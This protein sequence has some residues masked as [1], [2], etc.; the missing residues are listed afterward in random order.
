MNFR[1]YG[2]EKAESRG[3]SCFAV[4]Y[5]LDRSR[6]FEN[7]E[8]GVLRIVEAGR[9]CRLRPRSTTGYQKETDERDVN[10]RGGGGATECTV[11]G[12]AAG[13]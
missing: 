1:K 2:T 7:V 4:F 6:S 8:C 10:Q 11:K 12:L 9:F 13:G 5:T 3:N